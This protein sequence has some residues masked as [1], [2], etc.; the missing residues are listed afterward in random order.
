MQDAEAAIRSAAL[1]R[2]CARTNEQ[3]HAVTA[4]DTSRHALARLKARALVLDVI[5][6]RDVAAHLA[7][8][9]CTST[10]DWAWQKQL[11]YYAAPDGAVRARMV[12]AEFAYTWEYQGNAPRLVYTPLTDRCYLTLT[13]GMA[14]GYGG[15]P[16][17]PAGTGKTESVK[18]LGQVRSCRP[19]RAPCRWRWSHAH[20]ALGHAHYSA[21]R[22]GTGPDAPKAAEVC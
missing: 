19:A 10:A 7:T 16:Y 20:A 18:A 14:L 5:H 12:D 9:R 1:D 15:S 2:L 21:S 22:G 6:Q 4:L 11:R 8:E 17:G 13:Q 3:L